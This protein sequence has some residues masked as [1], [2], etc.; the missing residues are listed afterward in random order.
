LEKD[1]QN[2]LKKHMNFLI[3]NL[4]KERKKNVDDRNQ[5]IKNED[6]VMAN[7]RMILLLVV[8]NFETN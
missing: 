1:D 4:M 2:C 5:L 6:I 8:A 7:V 3:K